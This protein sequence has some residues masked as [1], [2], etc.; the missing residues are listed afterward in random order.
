[1]I[2]TLP[3]PFLLKAG[4]TFMTD[5][6]LLYASKSA[7]SLPAAVGKVPSKQEVI[8]V[9]KRIDMHDVGIGERGNI[10]QDKR[11]YIAKI[12]QSRYAQAIYAQAIQTFA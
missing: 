7:L 4:T 8:L 5:E 6:G 12:P 11:L 9:A 1:V 3:T 10:G 2:N